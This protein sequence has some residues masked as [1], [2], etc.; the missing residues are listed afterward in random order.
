MQLTTAAT[1]YVPSMGKKIGMPSRLNSCVADNCNCTPR[2]NITNMLELKSDQ[3]HTFCTIKIT[4]DQ[5]QNCSGDKP[6]TVGLVCG[7]Y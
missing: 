5:K 4:H 6:F 7:F 2:L 1:A 3:V